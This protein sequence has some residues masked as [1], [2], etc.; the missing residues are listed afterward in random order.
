MERKS[1]FRAERKKRTSEDQIDYT[2][3]TKKSVN[4]SGKSE[5]LS[6]PFVMMTG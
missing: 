1:V 3:N 5:E 4:V 6:S 2:N